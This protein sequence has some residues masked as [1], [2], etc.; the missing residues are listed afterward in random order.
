M[1]S[2]KLNSKISELENAAKYLLKIATDLRVMTSVSTEVLKRKPRSGKIR[3]EIRS[4]FYSKR[5]INESG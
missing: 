4:K 1:D 5:K 2:G 3:A